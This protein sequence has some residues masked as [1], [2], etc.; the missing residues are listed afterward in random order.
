MSCSRGTL[1]S[2]ANV[3]ANPFRTP[4]SPAASTSGRCNANSRNIC[5]VQGPMP[6]TCVSVATTSSS[7][8]APSRAVGPNPATNAAV[9]CTAAAFAPL[10]PASRSVCTGSD[11]TAA[12][13][14]PR[15]G[16]NSATKRAQID[17]AAFVCSC[18]PMIVFAK[19]ANTTAASRRSSFGWLLVCGMRLMSSASSG[20]VLERCACAAAISSMSVTSVTGPAA[21]R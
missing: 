4:R 2:A 9:A 5:A 16:S 11:E 12:G 1:L 18:C 8:I 6:F 17:A 20:E 14:G 7:D 13:V 19:L 21:R 3:A 10:S 15:S